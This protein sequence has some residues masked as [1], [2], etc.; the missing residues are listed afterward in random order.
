LLLSAASP[1]RI[2]VPMS[3]NTNRVTTIDRIVSI[4]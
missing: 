2:T 1:I 4:A 3:I